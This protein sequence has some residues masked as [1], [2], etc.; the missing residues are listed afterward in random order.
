MLLEAIE[1]AMLLLIPQLLTIYKYA[2]MRITP[3]KR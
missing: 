3:V 2:L 1:S